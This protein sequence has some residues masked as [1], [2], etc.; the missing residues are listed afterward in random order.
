MRRRHAISPGSFG[1]YQDIGI[2][3]I[4]RHDPACNLIRIAGMHVV[5]AGRLGR[6]RCPG[7]PPP[8]R[9]RPSSYAA[10]TKPRA[11]AP[12]WGHQPATL[13][14]KPEPRH[15]IAHSQYYF[16]GI[17]KPWHAPA[18]CHFTGIFSDYQDISLQAKAGRFRVS[19]LVLAWVTTLRIKLQLD[20]SCFEY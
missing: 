12:P 15:S 7:W 19:V 20:L 2:A 10:L 4:T 5:R 3:S 9:T 18:P 6:R 11:C 16:S 8:P 17:D 1:H 13:S 14:L